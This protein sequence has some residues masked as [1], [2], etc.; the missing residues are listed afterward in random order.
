VQA[1]DQRT[2][3]DTIWRLGVAFLQQYFPLGTDSLRWICGELE[4][5]MRKILLGVAGA[6]ALGMTLPS[7]AAD[8]PAAQTYTKAP[9][10]VPPPA[11][12]WTGFYV[13][14]HVGGG[15][16][17]QQSMEIAPG[18]PAFPV[19]SVFTRNST[20]GFLGGV[21]GGF[22]WQASNLVLGVEG[23]Y[24]W[25]DVSGTATTVN[26]TGFTSTVTA[27]TNGYELATGRIGYAA[28]NWLFFAKGGGAWSQGNS[29]G[30]GVLAG[31]A[32][33][34]TTTSSS[35][36]TGWVAGAGIEWGFAPN[37]SAKI[38]YNHIDFGSTNVAIVSSVSGIS[39]VSST[40]RVEVVK[41]GVNYHFNWS[42][43]VVA[44]Y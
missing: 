5:A 22:N 32:V 28:D 3:I 9:V 26:G 14:G 25:A 33:F 39:N 43:P 10:Y 40:D 18:T 27:K 29:N 42:G 37:W 44:K 11:Y 8:L 6:L 1:A 4:T 16:G 15:W 12:N 38:E 2:R 7:F 41:G 19:G 36:R 35:N 23:E 31:G 24:S 21:Q 20:S 17:S 34:D 13:G 30:T